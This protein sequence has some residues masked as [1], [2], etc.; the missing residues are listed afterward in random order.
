[1]GSTFKDALLNF[2]SLSSS[3][4][5]NNITGSVGMVSYREKGSIK[6]QLKKTRLDALKMYQCKWDRA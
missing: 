1:M 4:F 5:L 6:G 3:K 2:S